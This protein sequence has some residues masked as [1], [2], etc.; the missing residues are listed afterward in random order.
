MV[1]SAELNA[2]WVKTSDTLDEWSTIVQHSDPVRNVGQSFVD[3]DVWTVCRNGVVP[4]TGVYSVYAY[5]SEESPA[6]DTGL[7]EFQVNVDG[8]YIFGG[9]TTGHYFW[10]WTGSRTVALMKGEKIEMKVQQR[11]G[12]NRTVYTELTY[13]RI[14]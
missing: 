6:A 7:R 1:V 2:I 3:S 13:Q 5:A 4:D 14:L 8:S 11:S 10:R 9:S 12:G